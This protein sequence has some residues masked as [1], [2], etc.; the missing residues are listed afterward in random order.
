MVLYDLDRVVHHGGESTDSGYFQTFV[1]TGKEDWLMYNDNKVKKIGVGTVLN[2]D[3][4][5]LHLDG[6]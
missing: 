1:R 2:R 6:A 3:A 4:F 5:M